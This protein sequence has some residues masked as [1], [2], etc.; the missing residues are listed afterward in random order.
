MTSGKRK[1]KIKL[2]T[3][4]ILLAAALSAIGC[5]SEVGS[6]STGNASAERT[7]SNPFDNFLHT[8]IAP[9]DGFDFPFGNPDGK[10]SYTDKATGKVHNGWYIAM[11]FAEKYSM[12]I[13]TGEDWNGSGGGDTDLGQGVFAVANG[14]VVFAENCGRLWGNVI[15]IE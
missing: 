2:H 6:P 7:S 10:G 14:R 4:T 3:F 1:M 8:D 5:R 15:I 13:H 9:A 11:R 12:G